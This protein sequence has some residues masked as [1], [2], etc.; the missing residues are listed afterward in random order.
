[1]RGI[2][3]SLVTPFTHSGEV[4]AK[5]LERL[6]VHCLENGA[7]GLVALG[8]TGE[9]ALLSP[10]EQRTV[11]EVCRAV[12]ITYGTPLIVGAGTMGTEDSI[13]QA[14][15]RAPLAD[16]LLV[17]VPYYLRPS[18]D[19]VVDHFAA[20][21]AAVD[22]PLVPYN[23]PYRTGKQLGA[24]TL[25]KIL[26]L[27]CVTGMK[28]CAGAVDADT[29]ALLAAGADQGILCGD[30]MYIYPMLQ[31]GASGG[32]AASACL[33]PA[34]YAAMDRAVRDGNA[35]RGLAIHNA[36]LPMVRA[37]FAEPSPSVLKACLAEEGLIDTPA[38]RAPLHAPDPASVTAALRALRVG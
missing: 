4:D 18:D 19:A 3:A 25:L 10:T 23:I 29:I 13:R 37:L 35:A 11:L 30:D 1:M 16:A 7:D 5:S 14:R 6:A 22:V 36:L 27:D 31:L 32:V 28:Q 12:S 17:V 2:H 26:A 34:A 38:V 20:V 8:T 24:D 9:A 33:A 15:E 21:G